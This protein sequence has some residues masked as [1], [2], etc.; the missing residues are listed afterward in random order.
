[1]LLSVFDVKFVT[2][3]SSFHSY[4]R[5]Q[6]PCT[7]FYGMAVFAVAGETALEMIHY[8]RS[9]SVGKRWR[10]FNLVRSL[11]LRIPEIT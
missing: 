4:T 5:P 9:M 10:W 2:S 8:T 7:L 1:M 3:R 11:R 6:F